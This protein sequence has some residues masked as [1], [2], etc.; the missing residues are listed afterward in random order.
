VIFVFATTEPQKIQQSAS[1]I[2]SRCQRFDFRR[3]GTGEIR[4][5]LREVLDGEGADAPDEALGTIARRA[6]GGLRDAL[7]LLDQVL[8]LTGGEVSLEAVRQ[9]MGLVEE[10]K[11]VQLLEIL[12]DHRHGEVFSF[13]EGLL[14][15]GYDL[16][17]FYQGLVDQLR[18]LLRLRLTGK[19]EGLEIRPDLVGTMEATADRFSPADLVR[20]LQMA[21][22]LETTGNLRRSA[23]P[24][25]LLEM[26]LL[27][28]SYLDRTVELEELVRALGGSP[29]PDRHRQAAGTPSVAPASAGPQGASE[30]EPA[31][32]PEPVP[33]PTP[34][35][36]SETVPEP[37]EESRVNSEPSPE[38]TGE[39]TE[40]WERLLA[41]PADL[42]PGLSTFLKVA[43]VREGE[44]GLVEISLPPGPGHER[45]SE[46]ATLA[47]LQ[48]ALG[49]HLDR[50]PEIVLQ[51]PDQGEVGAGG[52]ISQETVRNGRLKDLVDKEPILGRA[53]EELDLELLD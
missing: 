36:V 23:Q 5:R 19:V 51:P 20:M 13:I 10:E 30:E 16:A 52:R 9:V 15:E 7:S 27:R 53:V 4:A 28:L 3:I 6:G 2:L 46:P 41:S 31:P 50:K 14:E 48:D 32:V 11:Y 40:A 45:L 25:V 49:R 1:P 18:T 8:A 38:P 33:E 21:S 12:A 24:R 44:G 42:P 37:Q 17:E 22:E 34:E 43:R 35:P 47:R 26:L 29:T 39:V